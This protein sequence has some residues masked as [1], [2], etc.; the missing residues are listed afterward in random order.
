MLGA[1]WVFQLADWLPASPAEA[2]SPVSR[3]G[4][5]DATPAL[6]ALVLLFSLGWLVLRPALLGR[7]RE[8]EPIQ[9]ATAAVAL[10]LVLSVETLLVWAANPFAALLLVP[11]VHL[12]LLAAF[13]EQ[14]SRGLL[15]AGTI[16]A[17]ALPAIALAYYGVELDL[18]LHVGSYLLLLV[19][20]ATNSLATGILCALVAGSL[21]SSVLIAVRAGGRADGGDI[22]VRGPTGYAGPGSLG[23]T[24]SAMRPD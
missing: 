12:C 8:S 13:P 2:V 16:G 17:L 18:G 22:T 23:G 1:A 14:P 4:F 21:V 19:S 20:S 9:P 15:L 3:P 10:S 24:S 7:D 6:I 11:A 5:G